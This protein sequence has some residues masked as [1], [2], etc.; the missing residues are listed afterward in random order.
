MR[1]FLLRVV[2]GTVLSIFALT[3]A[4]ASAIDTHIKNLKD[5]DP[6]VRAKAAYELGCG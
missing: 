1:R 5:K 4:C 2:L 3:L 6:E